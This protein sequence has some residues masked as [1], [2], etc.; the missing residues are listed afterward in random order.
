[1]NKTCKMYMKTAVKLA[2]N[3]G[4]GVYPNPQVGC[5][6]VKDNKIVGQ[7]Y[8]EFFGGPHAEINALAQAGKN[9]AAA[10]LYVTLEPCNTYGKR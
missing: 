6:I 3:G 4:S 2:Q 10:D 5:V 8:H 1:M 7:G 9:A